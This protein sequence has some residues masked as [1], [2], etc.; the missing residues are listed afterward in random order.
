MNQ[1][2][3]SVILG[4]FV[5]DERS[6]PK[7]D[8]SIKWDLARTYDE[9]IQKL[10]DIQYHIV[11]LDHDLGCFDTKDSKKEL[12]GY[13][14]ALFLAERKHE[15]KYVPPIVNCHSANT[16]GRNNIEGVIKRYLE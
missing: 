8:Q 6:L 14:I 12:T 4:L 16:P 15:G 1:I 5:D 7:Y 13:N 3:E 10:T 2:S 9:A 11:S